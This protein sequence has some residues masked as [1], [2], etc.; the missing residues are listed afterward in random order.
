MLEPALDVDVSPE[1]AL[2]VEVAP[3]AD[4]PVDVVAPDVVAT[5]D[6]PD[7]ELLDDPGEC[8]VL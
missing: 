1:V 8:P 7:F 5:V 2:D 6:P 4:V 3:E